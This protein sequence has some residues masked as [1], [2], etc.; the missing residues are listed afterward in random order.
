MKHIS[1]YFDQV[2]EATEKFAWWPVRSSFSK[3]QI[4]LKKYVLLKITY[5]DMGR[6]PIK[7]RSWDLIYTQ[8]EYLL[9]LIKKEEGSK[10]RDPLPKLSY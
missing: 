8:N 5:D 9:Y 4:W 1:A 7:G 2:E 6:P 3:K 10:S